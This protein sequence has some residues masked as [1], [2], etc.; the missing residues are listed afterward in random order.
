MESASSEK[1]ESKKIPSCHMEMR[2]ATSYVQPH[3]AFMNSETDKLSCSD[4]SNSR[5]VTLNRNGKHRRRIQAKEAWIRHQ[6]KEL[7]TSGASLKLQRAKQNA[8]RLATRGGPHDTEF[9]SC[10]NQYLEEAL[11]Q[12]VPAK[13]T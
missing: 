1:E 12:F 3:H 4:A 11:N 13:E 2:R 5:S 7:S 10:F 9:F 6:T 8:E